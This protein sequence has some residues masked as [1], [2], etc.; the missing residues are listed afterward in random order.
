ML[1]STLETFQYL[2]KSLTWR[3][4]DFNA[5]EMMDARMHIG[6]FSKRLPAKYKTNRIPRL[7]MRETTCVLPP[8]DSWTADRDREA[9][10]GRQ[11]KKEEKMLV[12]PSAI[13][14]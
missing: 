12:L 5:T 4:S 3:K 13:S 1:P 10:D 7:L 6:R 8:L 14:S 2:R 9:A 11:Q